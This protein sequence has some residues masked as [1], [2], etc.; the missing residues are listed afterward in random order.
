MRA[1]WSCSSRLRKATRL[2][3]STELVEVS[4]KSYVAASPA[5]GRAKAKR[6]RRCPHPR[7]VTSPFRGGTASSFGKASPFAKGFGGQVGEHVCAVLFFSF[8]GF[9]RSWPT[10]RPRASYPNQLDSQSSSDLNF[11]D[12]PASPLRASLACSAGTGLERRR[13]VP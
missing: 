8:L 4:P 11:R 5:P 9:W 3:D 10:G 12:D 6:R 2:S 13:V 7:L 1:S